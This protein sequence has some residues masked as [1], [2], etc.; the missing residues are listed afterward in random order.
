M[1]KILK[2]IKKW[3]EWWT[4][5]QKEKLKAMEYCGRGFF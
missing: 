2:K 3:N 5:I 4:F 1:K